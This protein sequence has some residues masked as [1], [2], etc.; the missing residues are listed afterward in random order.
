MLSSVTMS[1]YGKRN[2]DMFSLIRA[3]SRTH[4]TVRKQIDYI[5]LSTQL[6]AFG[7]QWEEED[8][9]VLKL[10]AHVIIIII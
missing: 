8:I 5:A 9:A 3:N 4:H 2:S 7:G 10:Q 6:S 1:H